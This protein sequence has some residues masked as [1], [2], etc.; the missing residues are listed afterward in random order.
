MTFLHLDALGGAAGDMFAAALLHAWPEAEPI[1]VGHV[2][3]AAGVACA[4]VRHDD[5]VLAGRRFRVADG[6]V[7][8]HDHV[9]WARLRA[10]LGDGRLPARVGAR[11]IAIFEI[12]AAA[13]ARVH[14]VDPDEVSFHEVGAADSVADIVA[15]AVLLEHGGVTGG[16]ISSLP[17]GR[18]RV[19]TA[20]G[21]LPVPAPA[22]ALILA[23]ADWH[24]DGIA[25]E[26]VTPTGAAILRHLVD[27]APVGAGPRGRLTA[28][29]IG[30]GTRRLTGISNCLRVLVFDPAAPGAIPEA[31]V[32]H[33]RLAVLTCEIDDQSGEDLATGLDRLRVLPFVHDAMTMPAFG[34]KG[35]LATQVQVLAAADAVEAAVEAV[36]RETTTIGL[37]VHVVEGRAL[38]RRVVETASG[39][40]VKLVERPGGVT[41]KAEADDVAS[42]GDA[43]ARARARTA[44]VDDALGAGMAGDA[45]RM[46]GGA[47]P[48]MAGDALGPDMAGE[49]RAAGEDRS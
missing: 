14:G 18:G 5:G 4:V 29:G 47:G 8:R 3:D 33:R 1:V 28:T 7:D 43:P 12:L 30:F 41:G 6:D 44:A 22:T 46:A 39:A 15:A 19:E 40:R 9:D 26:R 23:G 34:K 13:E 16:T 21:P 31:A 24:D 25:G 35:R 37:R 36:F 11:A 17:L 48:D 2:R 49:A 27:G 45:T 42:F 38:R 10:R 20:H 32:P